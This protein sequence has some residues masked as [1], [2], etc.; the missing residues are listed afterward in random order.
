[1]WKFAEQV[2]ATS[3]AGQVLVPQPDGSFLATGP[4]PANDVYTIKFKSPG[5]S[6]SG[7]KV[8]VLPDPSFPNKGPGRASS[9]N[10]VLIHT[11]EETVE[12]MSLRKSVVCWLFHTTL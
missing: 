9:G 1:M 5:N 4:A 3:Q 8:E 6:I 10:F 7:I 2:S 11:V 12:S